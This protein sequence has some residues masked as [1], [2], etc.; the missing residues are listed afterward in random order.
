[1]VLFFSLQWWRLGDSSCV[2][3]DG[4]GVWRPL[5]MVVARNSRYRVVFLK[6][7]GFYVQIENNYFIPVY[8]LV[9]ICVASLT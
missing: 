8:L 9:S 6:F 3:L 2:H 4:A 5:A 7:L 1:M